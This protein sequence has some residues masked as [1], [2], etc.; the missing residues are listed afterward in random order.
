MNFE[1]HCTVPVARETLWDFLLN[2]PQMASC[3]P[4][5]SNVAR[6]EDGRYEQ[7]EQSEQYTGQV[8]VKVG[9]IGLTLQGV[10]TIQETNRQEWRIVSQAEAKDRRVGGGVFLNVHIAL[11]EQR[12]NETEL[13]ILSEARLMGKLGEFGQPIIRRKADGI[14]A[15]FAKNVVGR[16]AT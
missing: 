2:I 5:A 1:H 15:E 14:V 9:P 11:S 7:N 16:F 3:V 6:K 4:G 13:T 12:T 10:M 8:R